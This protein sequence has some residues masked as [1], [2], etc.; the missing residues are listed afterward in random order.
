MLEIFLIAQCSLTLPDGSTQSFEFCGTA[1]TLAPSQQPPENLPSSDYSQPPSS[2]EPS[3]ESNAPL[4]YQ[5]L[6][7]NNYERWKEL[8][9]NFDPI[10][11]SSSA[12]LSDANS[13]FGFGQ[14]IQKKGLEMQKVRWKESERSV[15]AWFK[16]ENN[17]WVIMNWQGKGF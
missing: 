1:P 15:E 9:K 17:R 7:Q 10:S 11:G 8:V 2:R 4:S 6:T 5:Y 13:L 16:K 12:T 14:V 3:Q